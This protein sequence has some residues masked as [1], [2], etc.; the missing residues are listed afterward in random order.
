MRTHADTRNAW[1]V[2]LA[3]AFVVM[4]SG[5]F[6]TSADAHRYHPST[7]KNAIVKSNYDGNCG[8]GWVW[9]CG[10]KA[11]PYVWGTAGAHG[12]N[13]YGYFQEW[14]Y[15]TLSLYSCEVAGKVGHK[16]NLVFNKHVCIKL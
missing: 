10:Y 15:A 13:F 3:T 12:R 9:K 11:R 2:A 6:A 5:A 1:L 8:G 14:N 4:L 7:I 16:R